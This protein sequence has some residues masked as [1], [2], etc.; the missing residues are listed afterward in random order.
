MSR[1]M[2]PPQ[3]RPKITGGRPR[4]RLLAAVQAAGLRMT[5]A[6]RVGPLGKKATWEVAFSQTGWL[7]IERPAD[8]ADSQRLVG[9]HAEWRGPVKL[10]ASPT[11]PV[12]RIEVFAGTSRS[13]QFD[14]ELQSGAEERFIG[15]L[16][17]LFARAGCWFDQDPAGWAD[18][19]PPATR[20]LAAWL[21]QLGHPVA[22]DQD[23]NLRMTIRAGDRD[24]PVRVVSVPG[25]LRLVMSLGT[26]PS[27]DPV[28]RA[29][30][31]RLACQANQHV[32]LARVAWRERSGKDA[33]EV[34]VDLTNLASL[35]D[36]TGEEL[37][38]DMTQMA[39]RAQ[40]LA[41]KRLGHELEILADPAH[42]GLARLLL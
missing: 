28:R 39:V 5:R 21:S 22:M 14:R 27:L 15:L 24:R 4:N 18:W 7:V 8:G 31:V 1:T 11:G 41:L 2:H 29:A 33:C 25:E 16:A 3:E 6:G 10:V 13:E 26:W 42:E 12:Q 19:E 23:G 32:R 20:P 35:S 30:M 40:A 38:R 37:L 34:Q 36:E 9:D 17:G